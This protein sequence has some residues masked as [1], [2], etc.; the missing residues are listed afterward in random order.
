MNLQKLNCSKET[1]KRLRIATRVVKTG[2]MRNCFFN[3]CLGDSCD[4]CFR[5]IRFISC[6]INHPVPIL[7]TIH[8]YLCH[9]D[10]VDANLCATGD[11]ASFCYVYST[12]ANHPNHYRTDAVLVNRRTIHQSFRYVDPLLVNLRTIHPSFCHRDYFLVSLRLI[13]P[14]FCHGDF[15]PT[16][17]AHFCGVCDPLLMN[18]RMIHPSFCYGVS[19]PVSLRL[20]HASFSYVDPL[21][22]NLRTNHPSLCNDDLVDVDGCPIGKCRGGIYDYVCR[23]DHVDAIFCPIEHSMCH[24]DPA[25]ATRGPHG[26]VRRNHCFG[27]PAHRNIQLIHPTH[28]L[29]DSVLVNL[30]MS[31]CGGD[32]V[33][34][35]G[36][37]IGNSFDGTCDNFC[38]G[39]R[40]DAIFWW[41]QRSVCVV[42][43]VHTS[44]QLIQ[45]THCLNDSV[46]VNLHT[47]HP[48]LCSGDHVDVD[49]CPIG[50]HD[51]LCRGTL[52]SP[53]VPLKICT[54]PDFST[55]SSNLSSYRF[56]LPKRRFKILDRICRC[57]VIFT[58]AELVEIMLCKSG[59]TP[60]DKKSFVI[61]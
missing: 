39:D 24:I 56:Q 28:C 59:V 12:R 11:H 38:H 15:L 60:S 2:R 19:F 5:P 17:H 10:C 35:D 41:I 27:K 52:T 46:L 61:P 47:I 13:R 21:N 37:L 54:R 51:N 9:D 44:I 36:C 43:S 23:G 3:I 50:T 32:F 31:V 25:A 18:L 53:K 8:H 57:K 49:G 22:L 20:I 48:S 26:L 14:S 6:R 1:R 55:Y 58:N 40:F 4:S 45:P 34:V 33:D 30:R 42:E 29:I 16:I 7:H